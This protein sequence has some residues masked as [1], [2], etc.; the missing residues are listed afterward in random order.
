ME[1]TL[2]KDDRVIV[3]K[4][5]PGPFDLNRGDVVVFQDPDH[6]LDPVTP[7]RAQ[8]DR[9]RAAPTP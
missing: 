9:R 6:W 7:P 3:S 8:P 4:L 5:T 2:V 1:N